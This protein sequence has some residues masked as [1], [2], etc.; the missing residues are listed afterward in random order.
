MTAPCPARRTSGR[1]SEGE[2]LHILVTGIGG[3]I[4]RIVA[5]DLGKDHD[6]YGI[7]IR[8]LELPSTS[9]ADLTDHAAIAPLFKDAEVVIH[10]AAERRHEPEIGWDE[11]M[12][13]NVVAT[14]NVFDAAHAAGVRRVV[15][16]SSMH[17]MGGYEFDEPYK[18]IVAAR[19]GGLD[20]DAI[21]LVTSDAPTKPDSRYAASKVFGEALGRYYAEVEEMEVISVRLGAVH[22]TDRPGFDTRSWVAWLS[23][24][25][26]DALF[27][28]CVEKSG[29]RHEIVY[30]AS[31]NRW[32]VYDT[33]ASWKVLGMTPANNAEDYRE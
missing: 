28:A 7:D 18:S 30:G 8:P 26:V 33:P 32:K 23:N 13:P 21:P 12:K 3:T 20:P 25:D 15:F 31:A 2:T 19:Y 27:R 6:V 16:A 29:I 17:V 1:T 24:R 4:G 11:L 22:E 9:Q 5:Q 10:L 14:A